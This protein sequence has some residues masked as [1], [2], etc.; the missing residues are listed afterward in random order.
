MWGVHTCAIYHGTQIIE[1]GSLGP[2]GLDIYNF[3]KDVGSEN[4]I[5]PLDDANLSK[6]DSVW[7]QRRQR[8][9]LGFIEVISKPTLPSWPRGTLSKD[10]FVQPPFLCETLSLHFLI[11]EDCWQC[12]HCL[13]V[14]S[15]NLFSISII[16][17][18]HSVARVCRN[19]VAVKIAPQCS[20]IFCRFSVTKN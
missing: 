16:T 7:V 2:L 11:E 18:F 17:S 9:S 5:E 12:L 8:G 13:L 20:A 15:R 6:S 14:F 19:C 3:I 10:R 1:V 4:K